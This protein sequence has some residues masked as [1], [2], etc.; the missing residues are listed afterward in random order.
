[1]TATTPARPRRT[2]KPTL[3]VGDSVSVQS[4][5]VHGKGTVK[6]VK[7]PRTSYNAWGRATVHKTGVTLQITEYSSGF[8]PKDDILGKTITVHHSATF[9]TQ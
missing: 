1:M 6:A 4:M 9:K 2:R 8:L 3:K 5:A 7:V